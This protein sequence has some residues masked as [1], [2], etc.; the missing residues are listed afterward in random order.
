M[1]PYCCHSEDPIFQ[2]LA[3]SLV[4]GEVVSTLLWRMAVPVLYYMMEK[5]KLPTPPTLAL[6]P[7]T[8]EAQV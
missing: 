2:R 7:E 4:A 5:R 1:Q 6:A 8:S 3:I